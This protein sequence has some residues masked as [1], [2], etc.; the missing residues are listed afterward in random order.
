MASS[1]YRWGGATA[2]SV[3]VTSDDA[4]DLGD[5]DVKSVTGAIDISDDL[6]RDVG[7]VVVQGTA[8]VDVSNVSNGPLPTDLR[9]A[10]EANATDTLRVSAPNALPVAAPSALPVEQQSAVG[11]HDAQGAQIDPAM[12]AT[13][14]G[15]TAAVEA[16][17]AA[18]SGEDGLAFGRAA[19][20][21]AGTAVPLADAATPVPGD[22]SVLVQSIQGNAGTVYVGD[23]TVT[24]G[25]GYPLAPGQVVS[26]AVNDVA[27]LHV[28]ADNAGDEV[29]YIV[30][31]GV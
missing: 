10:L 19:V 27:T 18:V 17:T 12:D 22:K 11:V 9:A 13:V 6:A 28:D 2:Q 3:S 31:S 21:T 4:R 8:D 16:N 30:E 15:T 26:L 14:E 20:T 7:N 25:S 24:T 29:A 1:V 5:V 23:G